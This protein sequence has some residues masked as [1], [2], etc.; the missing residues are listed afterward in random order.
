MQKLLEHSSCNNVC[1]DTF[2]AYL[3]SSLIKIM[4]MTWASC[5]MQYGVPI[6]KYCVMQYGVQ[7]IFLN[8]RMVGK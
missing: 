8:K 7:I 6:T 1:F 2:N 3:N 4:I 5:V